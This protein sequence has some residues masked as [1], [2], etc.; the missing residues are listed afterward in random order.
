MQNCALPRRT[1]RDIGWNVERGNKRRWGRDSGDSRTLETRSSRGWNA[2]PGATDASDELPV[3]P[4]PSAVRSTSYHSLS[5]SFLLALPSY[6]DPF[7]PPAITLRPSC[8]VPL[9]FA[10][11][12][13]LSFF[14]VQ[15][16]VAPSIFF[17]PLAFSL[18][19]FKFNCYAR[20]ANLSNADEFIMPRVFIQ[21][22]EES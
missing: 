17:F 10:A 12:E 11:S 22:N 1:L 2:A 8:I 18:L 3:S 4:S 15:F 9:P 21:I 14:T 7:N 19:R 16:Y 6:L 20:I 13:V 5:A